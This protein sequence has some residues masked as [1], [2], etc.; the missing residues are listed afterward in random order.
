MKIY[1]CC[2]LLTSVTDKTC[3]I[4]IL[5]VKDGILYSSQILTGAA[6]INPL[7]LNSYKVSLSQRTNMSVSILQILRSCS[8]IYLKQT[9]GNSK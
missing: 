8:L 4:E 2:L 7:I 6:N 3:D 9:K 5:A 1:F